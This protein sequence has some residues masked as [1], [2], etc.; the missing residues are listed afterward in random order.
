MNSEDIFGLENRL[1][2]IIALNAQP[3][4]ETNNIT[5]EMDTF[6]DL[7][8]DS[9]SFI[10]MI[11]DIESEFGIEVEDNMLIMN[12]WGLISDIRNYLIQKCDEGEE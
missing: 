1:F 4:I 3:S 5:L 12:K 9:I 2:K 6:L 8:Y 10:K 11:I 7:G